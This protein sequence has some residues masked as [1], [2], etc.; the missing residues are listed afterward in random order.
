MI[1]KSKFETRVGNNAAGQLRAFLER[2]E[3]LEE[4]RKTIA[5]DIAEVFAELK[6]S[7]FDKD[8]AKV[9][10]KIRKSNTG[11]ADYSEKSA[12]VDLYLSALGMLGDEPPAPARDARE[13][14]RQ[15][16][17]A[18][19]AKP[20]D[21][22][23]N[24]TMTHTNIQAEVPH[25]PTTGEILDEQPETVSG[26]TGMVLG[27]GK[28]R[29]LSVG[30]EADSDPEARFESASLHHSQAKASDDNG[31]T[32]AI[33]GAPMAGEASRAS[34]GAGTDAEIQERP[35]TN[36]EAPPEA[37]PQA[38][39]SLVGTDTGMLADR[40]GRSE[41]E[42]AS[43]DL[44]TN[45]EIAPDPRLPVGSDGDPSIPSPE[46]GGAKM[47]ER[48]NAQPDRAAPAVSQDANSGQA[49]T[50]SDAEVPAFLKPAAV[51]KKSI[52]ELRPHCQNPSNCL[53]YRN[54]HC[55]RCREDHGE[56]KASVNPHCQKPATC[57]WAHSQALCS[58]CQ[59]DATR[60]IAP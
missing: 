29:P 58:T 37:G 51:Q 35:S 41:G 34:V 57:R 59:N 56:A 11:L 47:E 15:F 33:E 19:K 32:S 12:Q 53:G 46:A 18:V 7:G 43:V 8:A 3:R 6:G 2:I 54:I 60:R 13:N 44:P 48:A 26:E 21:G 55:T 25:D 27:T 49:V 30:C 23:A 45:S 10:L 39:A 42:A 4:E 5:D 28:E 16:P 50:I 31:G 14:I 22:G 17:R 1:R 20:A 52:A 24:I 38:E 40:E 9:V 36:D